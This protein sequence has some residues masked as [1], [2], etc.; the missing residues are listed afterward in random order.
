MATLALVPTY[1]GSPS[2]VVRNL[3]GAD[4]YRPS[5]GGEEVN[6]GVEYGTFPLEGEGETHGI[7]EMGHTRGYRRGGTQRMRN[8]AHG[9]RGKGRLADGGV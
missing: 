4:P 1:V 7:H 8:V 6:V 3:G 5:H 2:Q 9:G